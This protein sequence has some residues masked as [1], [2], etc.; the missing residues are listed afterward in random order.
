MI[1]RGGWAVT[2]LAALGLSLGANLFMAGSFIGQM[3]RGGGP[4]AMEAHGFDRFAEHL[5]PQARP[6]FRAAFAK[7][8]SEI[9]ARFA[10]VREARRAVVEVVR[11]PNLDRAA[12]DQALATLRERSGEAQALLHRVFADAVQTM[13]P[14]VRRDWEMPFG[15]WR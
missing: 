1:I 7:E 3:S 9:A 2:V 11:Q 15:G 5:P 14:D 12:L 6:A 4:G 8:G 13:P 10:A